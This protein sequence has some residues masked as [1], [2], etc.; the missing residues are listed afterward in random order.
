LGQA[1][2]PFRLAKAR[3]PDCQLSM[4]NK[5]GCYIVGPGNLAE[6]YHMKQEVMGVQ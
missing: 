1:S 2:E 5:P 3:F 4:Q 6:R